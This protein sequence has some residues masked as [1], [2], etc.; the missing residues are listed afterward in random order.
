MMPGLNRRLL[1]RHKLKESHQSAG[2]QGLSEASFKS[3]SKNPS[4]RKK[5]MDL[6]S[7]REHSRRELRAKLLGRRFLAADVDD[8]LAQLEKEGLLSDARF[9]E[10]YIASRVRRGHGPTRI[11]LELE[12]RGVADVLIAEH[13]ERTEIDWGKLAVTV[14]DKKFGEQSVSNF[15]EWARQAKFLQYRGFTNGQ[16]RDVLG[17]ISALRK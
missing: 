14:L 10:A 9:A 3:T 11:R 6:L 1:R 8:A 4:P 2:A 15:R 7:R 5:A 17:T 16:I 12:E 13:L